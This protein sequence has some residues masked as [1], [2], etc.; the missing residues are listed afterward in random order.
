MQTQIPKWRESGHLFKITGLPS[1]QI[2]PS[3]DARISGVIAYVE[4]LGD[5]SGNY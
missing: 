2:V 3:F 5:E 1:R 4:A